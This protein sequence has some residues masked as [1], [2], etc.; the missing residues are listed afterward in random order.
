MRALAREGRPDMF[1]LFKRTI[2][3]GMATLILPITAWAQ[4]LPTATQVASNIQLGWNMGNT[5]EAQCGETA[6]GNPLAS[7]QLINAVK[8]AGFK[9]DT[10]SRSLGLSRESIHHDDR[11]GMDGPRQTGG[12]LRVRSGNVRHPQHPLGWRLAPGSSVVSR[13]RRRSTRNNARTGRR[14]QPRSGTTTSD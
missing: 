13:S 12:R 1:K 4:T 10:H 9:H 14:S 6:W 5:L 7:Q 2:L 3:I 11:C 8:A